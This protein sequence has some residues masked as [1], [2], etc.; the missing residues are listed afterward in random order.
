MS[1][2]T[3]LRRSLLTHRRAAVVLALVVAVGAALGAGAPRWIDERLDRTLRDTVAESGSTARVSARDTV[4]ATPD[5]LDARIASLR[6]SAGAELGDLLGAGRWSVHS[7]AR[8]F[9]TQNGAVVDDGLRPRRLDVRFP[10][11]LTEKV[12]VVEGS[13]PSGVT[14]QEGS[15]VV[16]VVATRPV[17]EA[18]E[19]Q[20]GDVV[21][22][23]RR[24]VTGIAEPP[25][26]ASV[27]R[28]A[29]RLT[30]LIEPAD[31]DDPFWADARTAAEPDLGEPGAQ[32]RIT[33]GTL[34]SGPELMQ[35]WI[36]ATGESVDAEWHVAIEAAAADAS[37]LDAV[38]SQLRRLSSATMWSS[39]L[40][41]VLAGYPAKRSAAEGV[42]G[43]GIVSL[44]ALCLALTLLAVRY[45]AERRA[46]EI[47]LARTRGAGRGALAR[48]LALDAAVVAVPAAGL[49]AVAA[50]ATVAGDGGTLSVL[51][52]AAPAAVATVALPLAG[53]RAASRSPIASPGSAARADTAAVRPTPRRL[54]AEA[55]AV[56]VAGLALWLAGTRRPDAGADP[57]V[58]LTPILLAAATG[59]VIF[60]VVPYLLAAVLPML[61]RGDAATPFLAVTRAARAPAHAVLPVIA[62]LVAIGV[63]TFGGTVQA[64][65]EQAR[66]AASW[67]EVTGDAVAESDVIRV[68]PERIDDIPGADSVATGNVFTAQR[69]INLE[70]GRAAGVDI[71]AVDVAAWDDV[72][73]ASPERPE[74]LEAMRRSTDSGAPAAVL[75]GSIDVVGAGDRL[76]VT[77]GDSTTTVEVVETFQD[78]PGATSGTTLVVPMAPVAEAMPPW[79]SVVYVSGDVTAA[80]VARALEIEPGVVSTRADALTSL[81]GDSVLNAVLTVFQVVTAVSA[82]LAAAAAVLGLAIGERAR[83]H[84]LSVLRTLGLTT[85]QSAALTA[86]EVVPVSVV[87]ALAGIGVGT[88]TG[89][90]IAGALDLPA[91]SGALTGDAPA[92]ANLPQAAGTAAAVLGVVLLAVL[93]AVVAVRRAGLGATVQAGEST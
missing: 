82:V 38:T 72:V 19:L 22:V 81:Y 84:G 41:D 21:T 2:W 45:L 33:T 8:Y 46:D 93:G 34:L 31:P 71:L 55:A 17:A 48:L 64:S 66:Q 9:V 3:L 39:G 30:G 49:A 26:A 63:A 37:E 90:V 68:D 28:P 88:G 7:T 76:D 85:R 60:R 35:P 23:E 70:N 11:E 15:S 36:A 47:A 79:P 89:L 58:S 32:P 69:P 50:V 92:V 1:V 24:P 62:L 56:V 86:A 13:P 83:L 52:A 20:I 12:R 40:T 65:V 59:L 91:L 16:D 4:T 75:K 74:V 18:L 80:G 67:N 5:S 6:S 57:V 27:Q 43:F 51:L 61:R 54:V 77:L 10:D 29:V 14:E 87:A 53:L 73:A 42:V 44:A 78:V 25:D